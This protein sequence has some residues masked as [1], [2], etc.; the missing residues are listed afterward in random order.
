MSDRRGYWHILMP[1]INPQK[2]NYLLSRRDPQPCLHLLPCSQAR[3]SSPGLR[4]AVVLADGYCPAPCNPGR[5]IM[6]YL[7]QGALNSVKKTIGMG[8]AV[9]FHY[10]AA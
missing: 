7:L 10:N 2:I 1:P 3:S 6:L 8:T 5:Q 9:A 4:D